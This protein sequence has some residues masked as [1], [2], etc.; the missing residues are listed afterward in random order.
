MPAVR[1]RSPH[2][3]AELKSRP[4]TQVGAD[5]VGLQH[6]QIRR[7]REALLY[8]PEGALGIDAPLAVMLHGAGGSAENGI[9]LLRPFADELRIVL[10]APES[11]KATL[12]QNR[13]L[14]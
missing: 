4:Q 12:V 8:V 11:R 2:S 10:L 14:S 9:A 6:L 1:P 3:L 13:F 5:L 7:K